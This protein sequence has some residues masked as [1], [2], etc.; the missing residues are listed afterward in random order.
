MASSSS[1]ANP[2]LGF[3]VA[4]KL[5]KANYASWKVQ[6]RAAV[7]GARLQGHLTGASK[8]PAPKLDT[9]L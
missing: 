1:V 7:L 3:S 2:L 6:V 8:G 4:E 9:K 5:H